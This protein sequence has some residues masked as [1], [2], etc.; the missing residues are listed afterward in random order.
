VHAA[1]GEDADLHDLDAVFI[2]ADVGEAERRQNLQKE[3]EGED[4]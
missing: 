2:R 4:G 3:E 1:L